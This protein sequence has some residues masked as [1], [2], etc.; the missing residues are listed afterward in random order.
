MEYYRLRLDETVLYEGTVIKVEKL[1][2]ESFSTSSVSEL[3]LTNKNIVL[4]I[5]TK[6]IFQKDLIDVE[7][8]PLSEIKVFDEIPQI[9]QHRTHVEIY[10]LSG[11]LY[12]D[13]ALGLEASKFYQGI[14]QAITGKSLVTRGAEK[15]K[16]GIG[17]VDD[18]LGINTVATVKGVLENGI[19]STFLG[20]FKKK[21][22]PVVNAK[23]SVAKD[24]VEVAK[25]AVQQTRVN[26]TDKKVQLTYDEQVD[27]LN[28][29]KSLLDA[30]VLTQEEFDAKKKEILGL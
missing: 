21:S 19:A 18:T 15:V 5:R 4:T 1:G 3:L 28:K 10:L 30:G 20:G 2:I 23:N 14:M 24:I 16:S 12:L 29:M 7:V 17:L 26:E 27:A 22:L 25:D 6:R 8:I 13:F 9:K 11:E